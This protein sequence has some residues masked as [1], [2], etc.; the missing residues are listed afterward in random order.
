MQALGPRSVVLAGLEH[1]R[2]LRSGIV[3]D[4]VVQRS[5]RCC[6]RPARCCS[7]PAAPCS[8]AGPRCPPAPEC[9][10]PRTSEWPTGRPGWRGSAAGQGGLPAGGALRGSRGTAAWF[11]GGRRM[12]ASRACRSSDHF[13]LQTWCFAVI[14]LPGLS[15]RPEPL[16]TPVTGAHLFPLCPRAAAPHWSGSSLCDITDVAMSLVS[17]GP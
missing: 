10:W 8:C 15:S 4:V 3:L 16:N 2:D 12:S 6:S 11:L 13:F 17:T 5:A 9:W 14:G 1:F 7:R